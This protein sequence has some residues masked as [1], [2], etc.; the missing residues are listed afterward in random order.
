M[1]RANGESDL[2]QRIRAG[3]ARA[4]EACISTYE[5]RLQAFVL[6][7]IPDRGQA[8]DLVQET[9]LGFLTSLP[10]Y[11]PTTPVENFLFAIAA[12][13]ITDTLRRE[14]RR[15]RLPLHAEEDFNHSLEP[16]G[17]ARVASSLARSRE[18]RGGEEQVVADCLRELIQR[19]LAQGEFTRLK[20]VELLLVQGLPNREVARHL[21]ITEQEVANHKSYAIGKMKEAARRSSISD[22]E[23]EF[24][25]VTDEP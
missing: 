8:E 22:E 14:G 17:R 15:P 1:S 2:V 21:G 12:H 7:R 20:C 23:L 6:S 19:W 11:D 10:N 16:A 5:G 18:R 25:G 24:L 4:W 9:F 13:K 3:D